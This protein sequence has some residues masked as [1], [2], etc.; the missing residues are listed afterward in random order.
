VTKTKPPVIIGIGHVARVGKDTAAEALCRDLQ[1]QRRA[2]ADPLKELALG[3]DP[4]V[5]SMTRAMNINSGH[6]KLAWVVQGM[7]WDGAKDAYTEVRGFLQRLGVSARDV[8]GED[9]WLNQLFGWVERNNVERLVVPDV[10]FLNEAEA[11]KAAG[12]HV[13]RINRPG[14]VGAGHVSET[15]LKDWGGWAAEFAND[16]WVAD[17]QAD[18]VA[19]AKGVL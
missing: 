5:T 15:E 9:V 10:R 18:V 16:R 7:G 8:F 17:L 19:W 13:I 3:A 2:L 6:G 1:F 4:L 12:G 11:I 14:Q